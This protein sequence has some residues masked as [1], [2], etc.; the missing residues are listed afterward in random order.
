MLEKL[1]GKKILYGVTGSIATYKSP[2]IVREFIKSGADVK[3]IMT[4]SAR[5]FVTELVMENLTRKKVISDMFDLNSQSGGALHI[6]AAHE[7][8]LM[9][10]APCSATT[11]GKIANSICDNVLASIAIALPKDIPFVVSPA[12][13]STMWTHPAT[14]RNYVQIQKDGAY[15]IEPVEGPLSSGLYGPGRFPEIQDVLNFCANL[16]GDNKKNEYDVFE[17]SFETLENS[18][19]KIKFDADLELE[20]LKVKNSLSHLKDKKV[21]VNAGPTHEKIDDVRYITNYS[22]GK[23]GFAIAEA[24]NNAGADVTLV[25]GPVNLSCSQ[26][27]ER[28]NVVSAMDMYEECIKNFPQC[29]YAILSAAVADFTPEKPMTGKIK[30]NELNE[31]LSISFSKTKDILYELGQMKRASQYLIGF[32]LE[33]ENENEYGKKKLIDKNCDMIVVNSANKP[34]SGFGGDKNTVTILKK[35]GYNISLKPM[36]KEKV[37]IE[38]LKEVKD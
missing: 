1:K 15:V 33:T 26:E 20:K 25:T 12:M 9:L 30:K 14:Q 8:D 4:E 22:T 6:E 3:V 13:D 19:E 5:H 38:I 7:C 35:N 28:I 24:A 10:I 37:A 17:K 2:L 11:M 32:A 27:I 34:D 18:V 21:L 23:M 16:L 31:N 36:K 29:D